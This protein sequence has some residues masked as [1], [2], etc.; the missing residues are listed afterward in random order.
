MK[1][2]AYQIKLFT[3]GIPNYYSTR[4]NIDAKEKLKIKERKERKEE[5]WNGDG[6]DRETGK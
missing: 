6:Q 2:I 5:R 4:V 1:V 3:E